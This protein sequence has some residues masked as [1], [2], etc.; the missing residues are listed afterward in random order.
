MAGNEDFLKLADAARQRIREIT[1]DEA[2][3]KQLQGAHLIDVRDGEEVAEK[4]GLPG[5]VNISRGRLEVK[6]GDAVA[7]KDAPVVLYCAGGNRGALA[8]DS[9]RQMGYRN[10]FNVSGGLNAFDN[11]STKEKK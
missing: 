3:A 8:A 6:I 7:D 1:P 5:A 11:V 4:P 9:L 10:V 2:L